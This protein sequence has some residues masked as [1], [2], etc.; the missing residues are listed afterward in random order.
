MAPLGCCL[1]FE[2]K[3]KQQAIIDFRE[4]NIIWA[5]RKR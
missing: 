5:I 1:V 2:G 4:G 3:K